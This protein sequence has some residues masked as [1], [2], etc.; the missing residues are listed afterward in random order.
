MQI[1]VIV[2]LGAFAVLAAVGIFA[3]IVAA[4]VTASSVKN[5]ADDEEF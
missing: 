3:G 4:F 1:E 2:A 5:A